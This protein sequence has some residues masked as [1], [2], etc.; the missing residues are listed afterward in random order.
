VS[1]PKKT[2]LGFPPPTK[3]QARVLW[4]S[5]TMF[6]VAVVM[7]LLGLLVWGVSIV[8]HRLSAVMVPMAVALILAYILN[9][10]VEFLQHKRSMPRMWA[11]TFV[12]GL[13]ALLILSVLAS[14]LPGLNRESRKLVH[15]A[16]V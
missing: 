9:P 12:F 15:E 1:E 11:V 2:N 4:F 10:V 14:A 3:R 16:P 5:L 13:A 6:S 8:L 7:V